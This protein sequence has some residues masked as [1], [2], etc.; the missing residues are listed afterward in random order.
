MQLSPIRFAAFWIAGATITVAALGFLTGIALD[1]NGWLG[2]LR[3]VRGGA[4]TQGTVVRTEPAN[5]CLAAYTF[6]V[7]GTTYSGIGNACGT[8]I[9]QMV[10]VTYLIAGPEQSCLGSARER[11]HNELSAFGLG[12]LIF[13]P[14]L[15]LGLGRRRKARLGEAGVA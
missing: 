12:G 4:M 5:H 10:A 1:D 15:I 11:L 2:Y 9:G 6:N 3:L 8:S 13:P 7:E 14:L